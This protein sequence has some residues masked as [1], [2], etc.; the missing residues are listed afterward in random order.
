LGGEVKTHTF[1]KKEGHHEKIKKAFQ[2]KRIC[3][4]YR[5]N[6]VG[7]GNVCSYGIGIRK[8]GL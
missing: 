4:F 5:R 6:Y 8:Q 3:E 2:G 1:N 7:D